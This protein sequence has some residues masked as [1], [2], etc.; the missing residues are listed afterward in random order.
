MLARWFVEC[1]MRW[2]R[3][4][5]GRART[6]SDEC[7]R[8]RVINYTFDT[9]NVV[10]DVKPERSA[11]A[12]LA[13]MW[14]QNQAIVRADLL[15][16]LGE[17]DGDAKIENYR[18][19]GPAPWSVVREHNDLLRQV[20]SAFAHGN[21]YPALVGACALGERILGQLVIALRTDFVNH[22]ATTRRVRAGKALNDWGA[23]I[24]VLSG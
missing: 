8:Y 6:D 15:A 19:M 11:T 24:Q 18:A 1:A 5:L 10:L 16:E 23:L 22:R 20:R 9:R 13:E 3:A 14:R 12:E 17:L 21:F 2:V 7:R 4:E